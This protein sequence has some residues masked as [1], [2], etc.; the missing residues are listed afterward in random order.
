MKQED[1]DKSVRQKL[2]SMQ[3]AP[4]SHAEID[5]VVKSIRKVSVV[6]KW[7]HS[8][9]FKTMSA[10]TS[11]AIVSFIIYNQIQHKIFVPDQKENKIIHADDRPEG[12]KQPQSNSNLES[13]NDIKPMENDIDKSI[14]N[15]VSKNA[16]INIPNDVSKKISSFGIA[17]KR[18]KNILKLEHSDISKHPSYQIKSTSI[19]LNSGI[20]STLSSDIEKVND[21]DKTL[22]Q[23]NLFNINETNIDDEVSN[24]KRV[25]SK[26][27]ESI[28]TPKEEQ[29]NSALSATDISQQRKHLNI[30]ELP[31]NNKQKINYSNLFKTPLITIVPASTQKSFKIGMSAG[32]NDK[33]FNTKLMSEFK[34]LKRLSILSGLGLSSQN[35][36]R[37]KTTTDFFDRT[38]LGFFTHFAIMNFSDIE[39]IKIKSY[40][41]S[42]PLMLRYYHPLW[43]NFELF[44][45]VGGQVNLNRINHIT[46]ENATDDQIQVVPN[47]AQNSF[48]WSGF[49]EIGL[50]STYKKYH[51]QL[52]GAINVSK[53]TLIH[54]DHHYLEYLPEIRLYI[55][56][57]F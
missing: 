44:G 39:D 29:I 35:H 55:F 16:D 13:K 45:S 37:Y 15:S 9:A 27:G 36:V 41:I 34:L 51:I 20:V 18:N 21:G 23:K 7:Y 22:Q 46:F 17:E 1:F 43:R 25:V 38:K 12:S 40:T 33:G 53:E 24:T 50:S 2:L 31:T 8:V 4:A 26:I 47:R 14:A 48:Y 49:S 32:I 42:C 28:L 3:E 19:E 10:L 54:S 5:Q 6:H 56:R 57:S 11:I 30:T 52:S